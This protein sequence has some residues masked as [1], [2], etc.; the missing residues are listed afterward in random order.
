MV[1]TTLPHFTHV[2]LEI[3]LLRRGLLLGHRYLRGIVVIPILRRDIGTVCSVDGGAV[4]PTC[5]TGIWYQVEQEREEARPPIERKAYDNGSDAD[6]RAKSQAGCDD[7]NHEERER[8]WFGFCLQEAWVPC[9]LNLSDGSRVPM[10][11]RRHCYRSA[12]CA[13]LGIHLALTLLVLYQVIAALRRD[14]TSLCA[15][16]R[17]APLQH[18]APLKMGGSP[19]QHT[20]VFGI[21]LGENSHASDK[22]DSLHNAHWPGCNVVIPMCQSPTPFV[23]GKR[24]KEQATE[25]HDHLQS[26]PWRMGIFFCRHGAAFHSK[27]THRWRASQR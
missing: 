7:T 17:M 6:L 18:I 19:H 21:D 14:H 9:W 25:Q 15:P 1:H 4:A 2:I 27:G 13:P 26:G 8:A 23:H 24:K 12:Q 5:G 22:G 10:R 16:S 11:S 3:G 20:G